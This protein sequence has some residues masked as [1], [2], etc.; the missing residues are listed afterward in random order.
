MCCAAAATHQNF[1]V[2]QEPVFYSATDVPGDR[3]SDPVY[4]RRGN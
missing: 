1:I 3:A 4:L 2:T